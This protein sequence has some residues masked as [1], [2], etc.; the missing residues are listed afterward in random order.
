MTRAAM[1]AAVALASCAAPVR[2]V[3]RTEI[4]A[5][6]K[7]A[8]QDAGAW[9]DLGWSEFFDGDRE[10]AARSFAKTVALD[11]GDARALFGLATLADEGGRFAEERDLMVRILET[12]GRG[13]APDRFRA[14]IEV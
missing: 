5:A 12:H 2:P 1:L 10:A 7:L 13:A 4:E 8:P 11:A 6:V 14:A 9:R 3:P